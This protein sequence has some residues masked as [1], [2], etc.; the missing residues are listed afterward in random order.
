MSTIGERFEESLFPYPDSMKWV[1][2]DAK[3]VLLTTAEKVKHVL[4]NVLWFVANLISMPFVAAYWGIHS[5][6]S[7]CKKQEAPKI[8]DLPVVQKDL[9]GGLPEHFGFADSIFQT[10]GVGTKASPTKLPG[11]SNWNAWLNPERIEG[12]SDQNYRK[13]F[14]DVLGNPKP[15]VDLLKEMGVTAHRFSLEWSVI[16][17]EKGKIDTKAVGLYKNLIHQLKE[18]GIEPYVTLHHFV[19]PSWL[20]PAQASAFE[21][22]EN[23]ELFV[24]HS[25]KMM[26][27]FHEVT[28]WMTFNEPGV[29]GMQSC[30]RGEYPPG[31]KGDDAANGRVIRNLLIAHC[32]IY[33]AAK[34]KYGNEKQ[35]GITH[36]WLK[37][38][39]LEGNFVERIVAHYF[40]KNHYA[41]YN[42]FKT[43]R[44]SYQVAGKANIQF[45][46]PRQDFFEAGRFM[47]FLGVQCYGFPRIKAGFN[48]GKDYPGLTKNIHLAGKWGLAFG[49]SCS[50]G[51]TIQS[52]GPPVAP[53]DFE[54]VLKEA[55]VLGKPIVVSETGCDARSQKF[56]E[57]GFK[58]NNIVQKDY[59]EK[60]L[61]ILH[62]FKG[63]IKAFFAWTLVRGHLEWNRGNYP[64]LGLVDIRKDSH[65]NIVGRYLNPAAKLL[66]TVFQEKRAELN[67]PQA[68]GQ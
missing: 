59:F 45:T 36:Q 67:V 58:L 38:I 32:K 1:D 25:L 35:I 10:S 23:V 13:F 14:V 43:G 20:E 55:A 22:S 21:A 5:L 30:L 29:L 18:A 27:L 15:Y 68:A 60:A 31:L 26:D 61:S 47:D 44:F 46:I 3:P 6:V 50:E 42:F 19:S 9:T 57:D 37:F 64:L 48:G 4:T 53:A 51:G 54:K 16:E 17:P 49:S 11:V 33:Q 56:G 40:S 63:H 8:E 34:E 28:N 66:Q 39:P 41:I 12:T 24:E 65:R 7:R 52:F 62:K 2:G